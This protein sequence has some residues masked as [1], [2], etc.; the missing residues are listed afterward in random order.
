M[1]R[2]SGVEVIGVASEAE[3]LGPAATE[4]R[5]RDALAGVDTVIHLAAIAHRTADP[6]ALDQVNARW[7]VRLYEAAVGAGVADFV[8]LSTLKVLGDVSDAPLSESD[9]YRPGDAYAR[10]KVQAEIGLR[11]AAGSSTLT[12]VRPPLV[13]G[14][15]VKANFLALLRVAA[16]GARGV[17]LPF[18][19]ARAPRSLIGVHNLCSLI[20]RAIGEEGI[21][22]GADPEDLTVASLLERLGARRLV[23]MPPRLMRSL[24]GLSGRQ[25]V[26]E[27]LFLP[28]QI[29]RCASMRRLGWVP[30]FTTDEQL[31]ET[32]AWFRSR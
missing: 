16:W 11:S 23:D 21:V 32:L 6:A 15:G 24:L 25:A 19:G 5:M 31:E 10:S 9:A 20:R 30:P 26:Y 4:A 29:D 27:R 22:H 7:P 8:F 14:P 12:I 1:L 28:L 13:Y 17:P 18:G 2:A 3:A